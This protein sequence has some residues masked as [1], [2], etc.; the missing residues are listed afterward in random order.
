MTL[1]ELLGSAIYSTR[2]KVFEEDPKDSDK[3]RKIADSSSDNL[4]LHGKASMLKRE[5]NFFCPCTGALGVFISVA[6]E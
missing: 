2:V 3:M 4:L 1:R 5:V 6:L